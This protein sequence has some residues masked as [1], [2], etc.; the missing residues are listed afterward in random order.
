MSEEV[1]CPAGCGP[2]EYKTNRNKKIRVFDPLGYAMIFA[3]ILFIA[4]PDNLPF[5][6]LTSNL[7][8]NMVIG[9]GLLTLGAQRTAL[10]TT[11]LRC[12]TCKGLILE[13]KSIDLRLKGDLLGLSENKA[14]YIRAALSSST[15]ESKY[16]CPDCGEIMRRIVVPYEDGSHRPN[17]LVPDIIEDIQN[18][19]TV[20]R[21]MEIDGCEGCDMLWFKKEKWER[22]LSK[23]TTIIPKA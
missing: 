16:A 20:S 18:L 23:D 10:V 8:A 6:F 5:D 14:E 13:S 21:T 3:G 11:D 9:I 2:M 7:M 4:A 1:Q 15:E 12:D 22:K 17:T 19:S